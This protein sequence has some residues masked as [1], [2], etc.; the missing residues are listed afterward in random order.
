MS[1][2]A[3]GGAGGALSVVFRV[4]AERLAVRVLDVHKVIGQARLCR[5]PRLP[6]AIAGITQNRG[7]IVT[8][9]DTGALLF[10]APRFS[11]GPESRILVLDR[12]QRHLAMSVDAID[13]IETLRLSQL[14]AGPLPALSIA[15][16]NGAAVLA[17]DTDRLVERM[18][19]VALQTGPMHLSAAHPMGGMR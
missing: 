10:G 5:L 4:G 16:H 3:S 2:S 11:A 1:E 12:L 8:V 6:E 19:E 13:E 17:V 14:P 9:F 18:L 15:E 7:R